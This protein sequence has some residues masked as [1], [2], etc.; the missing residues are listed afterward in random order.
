MTTAINTKPAHVI[1]FDQDP[2]VVDQDPYQEDLA[3]MDVA[4]AFCPSLSLPAA[5]ALLD[6]IDS[7]SAGWASSVRQKMK[8]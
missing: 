5:A 4:N 6:I 7:I 3:T 8:T 1:E 2:S